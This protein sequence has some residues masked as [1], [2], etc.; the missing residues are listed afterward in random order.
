MTFR[1]TGSCK[2]RNGVTRPSPGLCA[3]YNFT[4]HNFLPS[5]PL[6][7]FVHVF[8]CKSLCFCVVGVGVLVVLC[9]VVCVLSQRTF[10]VNTFPLTR[11]RLSLPSSYLSHSSF[12]ITVVGET[13][14]QV[15][16]WRGYGRYAEFKVLARKDTTKSRIALFEHSPTC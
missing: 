11:F 13:S 16:G 3:I 9:S 4:K 15:L 2:K 1:T 8:V 12:I 7:P 6:F 10:V 5:M 14:S